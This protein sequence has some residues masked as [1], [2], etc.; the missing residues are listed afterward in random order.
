MIKTCWEVLLRAEP[1]ISA[2]GNPDT[3]VYMM[4]ETLDA[5][6]VAARSP[7]PRRWLAS[8]PLLSG[9]LVETCPCGHNP[10]LHYYVSGEQAIVAIADKVLTDILGASRKEAAAILADAQLTFHYVAQRETQVF[11]DLCRGTC[12]RAGAGLVAGRRLGPPSTR[13][14]PRSGRS[15]R[16]RFSKSLV[17]AGR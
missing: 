15:V 11:C 13:R 7:T 4:D 6:F 16:P 17:S 3:L 9:G 2:L 8:H 5:F 14:R 10:F 1:P 12:A